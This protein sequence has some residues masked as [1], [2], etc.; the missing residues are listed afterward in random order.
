MQPDPVNL[1]KISRITIPLIGFYDVSDP[2][3]FRPFA[4][5]ERCFYSGYAHW[6]KGESICI[7]ENEASCQGG[8]Y[9]VGGVP[10]AWVVKFGEPGDDVLEKFA[11]GLNK[12]EGFK[13]SDELM[14]R[15]LKNQKPYKIKNRYVVM[16]PLK[17]EQYKHLKTVT[18]Y[19]NPDQLSLLLIG[20]EYNNSSINK[21]PV[22][23]PF[24][25]GCGQMAALLGDP[26]SSEPK[27][28]IGGTDIAMRGNLPPDILALTVNK[29]MFGQLCELD[30]NS[31]LYKSFWKN[32]MKNREENSSE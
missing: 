28:V 29:P 15:W 21:S 12:R 30:E 23:A 3:P 2:E 9:W 19:V 17:E 1:L 14:Y 13:S 8:G 4:K 16:G 11:K 20:A 22:S 31:I 6:L 10:P 18:F 27:A 7:S 5:T 25:S 32:L 26:E 24:G